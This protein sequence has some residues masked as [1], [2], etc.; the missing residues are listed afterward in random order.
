MSAIQTVVLYT[1]RKWGLPAPWLQLI[2]GFLWSEDDLRAFKSRMGVKGIR[3]G[4]KLEVYNALAPL[5][6]QPSLASYSWAPVA[7]VSLA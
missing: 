4:L 2:P 7:D 6:S 5:H 3:T 1:Q